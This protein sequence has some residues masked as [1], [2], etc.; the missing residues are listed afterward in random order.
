[1]AAALVI[2]L[3]VAWCVVMSFSRLYLG[4]HFASDVIAGMCAGAAWV[5]VCVSGFEIVRRRRG[6]R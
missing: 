6:R 2:A 4:V 5:A 1:V 3:A